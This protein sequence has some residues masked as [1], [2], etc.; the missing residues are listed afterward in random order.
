MINV[1]ELVR[2]RRKT[3]GLMVTEDARLV[4][5]APLRASMKSIEQAVT[6]REGWIRTHQE[7][8][9]K[10]LERAA[11]HRPVSGGMVLVLG[12]R[13][14]LVPDDRIKVPMLSDDLL[15]F[16]KQW[17]H[18]LAQPLKRWIYHMA[19]Q[20]LLERVYHWTQQTGLLPSA[21]TVGHAKSQW[22]SC[23]HDNRIR[24]SWRLVMAP[25][26]VLDYVVVH[27]LC[28]ILEKNHSSSFWNLV[29][30]FIPEARQHRL[31]LKE[32]RQML[33]IQEDDQLKKR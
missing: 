28:H 1:D 25:L 8:M 31:W 2:S 17:S 18:Q 22:G 9:R 5:R 24:L 20:I 29:M 26:E 12:E 11:E 4:V 33:D 16:P 21:V 27:E 7:N 19:Q 3:I 6:D 14:R 15:Y 13:R 30:H 32:N 10:R 23:T